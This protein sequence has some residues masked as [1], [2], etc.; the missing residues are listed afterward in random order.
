MRAAGIRAK[1]TVRS[2]IE[3]GDCCII[4]VTGLVSQGRVRHPATQTWD[5]SQVCV[6]A[7]FIA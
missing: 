5:A 3:V 6:R 4:Y 2:L 1:D 7:Y